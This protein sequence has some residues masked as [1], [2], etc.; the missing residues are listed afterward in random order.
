MFFGTKDAFGGS[1]SKPVLMSPS[2]TV[3]IT[4]GFRILRQLCSHRTVHLAG[5]F[6]HRC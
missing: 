5:V 6:L 1:W 4:I 2:G 3:A